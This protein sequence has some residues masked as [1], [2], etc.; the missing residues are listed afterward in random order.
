MLWKEINI[1]TINHVKKLPIGGF[2]HLMAFATSEAIIPS[3]YKIEM[4]EKQ[5]RN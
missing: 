4:D 1:K 3:I 2:F 5:K